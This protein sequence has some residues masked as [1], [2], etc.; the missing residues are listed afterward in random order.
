MPKPI[1]KYVADQFVARRVNLLR[2]SATVERKIHGQ[3][4]TLEEELVQRLQDMAS[5]GATSYKIARAEAMLKQTRATINTRYGLIDTSVKGDLRPLADAEQAWMKKMSKQV[6]N[7]NIFSVAVAPETLTEIVK[8]TL[9]RGAP[10]ADWW[11]KQATD[12]QQSFASQVRLGILGGETNDQIVQRIRGTSTGRRSVIELA[13]GEKRIV[14]D[15]SGGI[16]NVRTYQ[17]KALVRTS[18]QQ[19]AN[20]TN[21]AVYQENQDILKG[22]QLVATLDMRTTPL[23]RGLD[24][25]CWDFNGDPLEESPVQEPWPGNPPY[26]WQCRTVCVPLTKSWKDLIKEANKG[27]L[28]AGMSK[29]LK[30]IPEGTRASMDGQVAATETYETWLQGK[31]EAFQKE[32]LGEA[33]WQLWSDGKVSLREMVDQSGRPLTLKEL[34]T[35]E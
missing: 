35:Q 2:Y 32:I 33:R 31:P 26:H 23:C 30:E 1:A 17:A 4:K 11:A 20:D 18:V 16:M 12:L 5:T 8:N 22:R 15:F 3:L 29:T 9:I 24:G 27:K 25:G 6:F 19:V 7:T 21:E 14:G 34:A 10:S 28:P 13:S